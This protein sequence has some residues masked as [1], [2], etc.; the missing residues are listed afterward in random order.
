VPIYALAIGHPGVDPDEVI[1]VEDYLDN[2]RNQ[3]A[4]LGIQ[5]QNGRSRNLSQG[6]GV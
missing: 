5:S 3:A 4:K 1:T 6:N 2:A